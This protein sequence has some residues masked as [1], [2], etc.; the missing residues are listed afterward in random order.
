M[1]RGGGKA[2]SGPSPGGGMGGMGGMGGSSSALTPAP[3]SVGTPPPLSSHSLSVSAGGSSAAAASGLTINTSVLGEG[4]GAG[5]GGKLT[6]LR[7]TNSYSSQGPGGGG[8]A[9]SRRAAIAEMI[10]HIRSY[11][12][13][14]CIL[15]IPVMPAL[16]STSKF[17]I[18]ISV[19]MIGA[20]VLVEKWKELQEG[21]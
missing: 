7:R 11:D 9:E 13:Y 19:M 8:V 18:F 3:R 4:G 5:P 20:R 12:P 1:S 10:S 16:F 15:G 6:P 2:A 14:P 17:Y 21:F